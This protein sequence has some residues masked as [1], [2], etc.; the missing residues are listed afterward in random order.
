MYAIRSYYESHPGLTN[1]RR[2]WLLARLT[3]AEGIERYLHAK[4]V[5]QKRF[6]LRN[7]FV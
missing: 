1:E 3:A 2:R 7:N 5:G 4:Y 6:S